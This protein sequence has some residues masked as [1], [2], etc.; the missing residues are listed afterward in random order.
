MP[1]R[2]I[3]GKEFFNP[4]ELR[5]SANQLEQ[6]YIMEMEDELKSIKKNRN[7]APGTN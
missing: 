7:K 3:E 6:M 5:F 4:N 1:I 2:I